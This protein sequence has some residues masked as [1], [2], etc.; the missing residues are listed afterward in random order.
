MWKNW[1]SP[2]GHSMFLTG[3]PL[4]LLTHLILVCHDAEV[5]ADTTKNPDIDWLTIA[6]HMGFTGI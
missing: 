6:Y 1:A 3:T 4:L 5:P 2:V